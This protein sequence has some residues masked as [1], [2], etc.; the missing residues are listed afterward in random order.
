MPGQRLRRWPGIESTLKQRLVPAGT[1]LQPPIMS[2]YSALQ[3][4]T[5]V[6]AYLRSRQ[7]L[8]FVL[9]TVALNSSLSAMCMHISE[10]RLP[11]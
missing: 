9:C 4:W 2:I 5:V 11:L 1:F 3:M 10:T 6:T 7:L 8:L